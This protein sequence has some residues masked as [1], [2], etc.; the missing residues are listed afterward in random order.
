MP[1]PYNKGGVYGGFGFSGF[2]GFFNRNSKL[3]NSGNTAPT[4]PSGFRGDWERRNVN[5]LSRQLDDT[6]ENYSR[7]LDPGIN[8]PNARY[9]DRPPAVISNFQE[10]SQRTSRGERSFDPMPREGVYSEPTPL[11]NV[12]RQP[13]PTPAPDF[14]ENERGVFRNDPSATIYPEGPDY[15][16]FKGD[17][18]YSGDFDDTSTVPNRPHSAMDFSSSEEWMSEHTAAGSPTVTIFPGID[19]TTGQWRKDD[20]RTV[21]PTVETPTLTGTGAA[22]NLDNEPSLFGNA[23]TNPFDQWWRNDPVFGDA[24]VS[25]SASANTGGSI[26]AGDDTLG[27]FNNDLALGS[28]LGTNLGSLGYGEDYPATETPVGESPF[29]PIAEGT[30]IPVEPDT[31]PQ[32]IGDTEWT[33]TPDD[34]RFLPE[35]DATP[36][37]TPTRSLAGGPNLRTFG[38]PI[39]LGAY[40]NEPLSSLRYGEGYP[41][42]YGGRPPDLQAGEGYIDPQSQTGGQWVDEPGGQRWVEAAPGSTGFGGGN[43]SSGNRSG[44]NSGTRAP[45]ATAFSDPDTYY[46]GTYFDYGTGHYQHLHDPGSFRTNPNQGAEHAAKSPP[47]FGQNFAGDEG[48]GVFNP[49]S[50]FVARMNDQGGFEMVARAADTRTAEEKRYGRFLSSLRT[51][52]HGRAQTAG[53]AYGGTGG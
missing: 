8:T 18:F 22:G 49:D 32:D 40:L 25:A 51:S 16:G 44:G 20:Y 47:K 31:L 53:P 43:A 2:A 33:S 38:G 46:E 6:V 27:N 17:E 37:P 41:I 48:H 34:R 29:S 39:T 24:D 14:F 15:A 42:H 4:V 21:G 35:P 3:A 36:P 13:S 9:D 30:G 10:V 12:D 1:N 5:Q 28:N 50:G 26:W 52:A 11:P 23:G 45:V 7:N 19:Q